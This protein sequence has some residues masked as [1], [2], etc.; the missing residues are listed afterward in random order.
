MEIVEI[1]DAIEK[2]VQAGRGANKKRKKLMKTQK[3]IN[4]PCE[5]SLTADSASLM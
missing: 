1:T 4:V 3:K 2:V 5:H